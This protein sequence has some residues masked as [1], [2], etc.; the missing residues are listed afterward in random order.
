MFI[1]NELKENYQVTM[2][3][4]QLHKYMIVLKVGA[5]KS[6]SSGSEEDIDMN[7]YGT[8]LLQNMFNKRC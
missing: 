8:L 1:W 4:K 7:I 6:E 5:N 2:P 3:Q